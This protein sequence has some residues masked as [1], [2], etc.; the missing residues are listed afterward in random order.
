MQIQKVNIPRTV[1]DSNYRY[2]M[3]VL[4]V[5]H[6]GKK[7]NDKTILQNI[8]QISRSLNVEPGILV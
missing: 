6:I 7:G 1:V 4:Q 3:Q 8:Q 5:K 2:Q